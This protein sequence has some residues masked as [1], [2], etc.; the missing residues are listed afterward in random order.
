MMATNNKLLV[1]GA[2]AGATFIGAAA[3]SSLNGNANADTAA[4]ATTTAADT[5]A[6]TGGRDP[7]MGG[8][9]ANGITE[10]VLTGDTATKVT[11]AAK[12][13]APGATIERVETDAEGAAYEAHIV[14]ADGSHVTLK[15]DS[16]Y[17][18][19]GTEDGPG[20]PP[21]SPATSS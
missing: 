1:A 5:A 15:F 20:T 7:A 11:D 10:Q 4:T 9:T 18:L 2:I 12:A 6:P 8:H 14:K 16:S 21:Q 17:K 13:A 19:T 3:G